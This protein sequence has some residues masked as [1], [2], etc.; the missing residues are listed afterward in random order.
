MF[1][2]ARTNIAVNREIAVIA[3]IGEEGAQENPTIKY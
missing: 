1:I 3:E 2:K